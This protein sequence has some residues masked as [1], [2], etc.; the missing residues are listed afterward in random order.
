MKFTVEEYCKGLIPTETQLRNIK[1]LISRLN[2]IGEFY[3]DP[4]IVVAGLRT[5]ERNEAVGGVK[6]SP[7]LTGE[8]VDLEDKDYKLSKFLL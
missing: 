4:V 6:N 3:P 2:N 8:A 1:I 7:H 5:P